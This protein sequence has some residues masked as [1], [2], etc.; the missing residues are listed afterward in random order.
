[1]RIFQSISKCATGGVENNKIWL[2]NLYESLIDMGHDVFF[3]MQMWVKRQELIK[4]ILL[5]YQY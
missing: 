2:W 4:I 5:G 3:L 1:M